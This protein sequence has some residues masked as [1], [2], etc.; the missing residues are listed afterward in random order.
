MVKISIRTN[1]DQCLAK[2]LTVEEGYESFWSIFHP[3]G[4]VQHLERQ[5]GLHSVP[6][7]YLIFSQQEQK[8]T[9]VQNPQ[10]F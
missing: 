7:P 2:V 3:D 4:Q 8:E 1:F 6:L 10:K 5:K 9:R